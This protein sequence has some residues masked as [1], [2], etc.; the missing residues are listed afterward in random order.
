MRV[1]GKDRM[2]L[3]R[4]RAQGANIKMVFGSGD[5]LKVARQNPD[6]QV[7]FFAIG[8]E[9]TTPTTAVA[10]VEAQRLH[11]KNFSVFVN[12]VLTPSAMDAI[13]CSPEAKDGTI[14]VDGFVGPGHVSAIIGAQPYERFARQS[15]LPVVISGFEPMDLLQSILMLVRQLNDG[16]HDVELQYSRAVTSE[17]NV[18][19]QELVDRVFEL[20]PTFEWR[21]LGSLPWSALRL[22]PE[23]AE[24]DAELR[25]D[26]PYT[27]VADHKACSCGD[28]LKGLKVPTDCTIFGNACTPESPMGSCMVSPEGSCAAYYQYGRHKGALAQMRSA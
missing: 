24:L 23:F 19:A 8:F 16:R 4:A 10:V 20:R 1:P 22:R 27:P 18:K 11:L 9:T 6:K 5:A 12:H 26:V 3:M 7:I 28:I 21:G 13:L 17:G 15:R 14:R 2:T 25:F